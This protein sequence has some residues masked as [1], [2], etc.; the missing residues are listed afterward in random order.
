MEIVS[1]WGRTI[2]EEKSQIV[3]DP[4]S[5]PDQRGLPVGHPPITSFLGVPLKEDRK[6]IGM[7]ALAN[8]K[9]GYNETDKKN[10]E[11]LGVAFVEVLM[12]K[13]AEIHI[14]EN[15]KNLE[16]SN[17]ELKQ[18]AYITSHDLRE[19]LRMITSFLQ[20]LERRYK[21]QLDQDANEFIGFAVDGAKRLD[22]MTNDLLQYSKITS[23]KREMKPVNFEHVLEQALTNLTVQI[24]ENNAIITND[25]LPTIN[26]DEQLKVQLFQ[27]LISNSI[28]YRSQET[29]K[30]HISAKKEK[31]LYIFSFKDNGIGMSSKYLEKI[32][33][34]FQRLHTKEEYEGTGIGLAIAQKIV[35]QQGG[36]IWAES[37]PGKGSTFYFTIQTSNNL[38]G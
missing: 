6:T 36:Q 30:I 32:F 34:I 18:F 12:R 14:K 4:N 15:I 17:K 28:K 13:K 37:E 23:E 9:P 24:E 27:N 35:H 33:T 7:I 10:I 29:P 8:K 21:D 11:T 38:L 1:Y 3:N 20:L 19:P 2:N 16:Q 26:G 31:N 22:V 5:D 25:P